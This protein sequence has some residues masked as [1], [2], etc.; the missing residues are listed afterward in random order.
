M[1]SNSPNRTQHASEQ[2]STDQSVFRR[3]TAQFQSEALVGQQIGVWK[4]TALLGEG[5]MSVVYEAQHTSEERTAAIKLLKPENYQQEVQLQRFHQEA[6]TIRQFDHENIIKLYDFAE[7]AEF[8]YYMVLERLRGRDFESVIQEYA[9]LPMGW[10]LGVIEQICQAIETIHAEGVLHR[11]LK[12]S[13]VFLLSDGPAPTVKLLDFGIAKVHVEENQSKLTSTGTIIGTPSYLSPEQIKAQSSLTEATDLYSLGVIIYQA[14]TG[15]LPLEGDSPIDQIIK[16]LHNTPKKLGFHRPEF[17]G[18]VLEELLCQTLS[19]I[20]GERPESIEFLWDE[21][22]MAGQMLEDPLD[23][24]DN[25]PEIQEQQQAPDLPTGAVTSPANPTHFVYDGKN[26]SS[27][28]EINKTP[29]M[30]ILSGSQKQ[31]RT[32][33]F[34]AKSADTISKTQSLDQSSPPLPQ[35]PIEISSESPIE[36]V[37]QAEETTQSSWQSFPMIS[38]WLVVLVVLGLF[39]IFRSFNNKIKPFKKTT[40]KKRLQSKA[41][42]QR[43]RDAVKDTERKVREWLQQGA[44]AYTQKDY[45]KAII[46]WNKVIRHGSWPQSVHNPTLYLPLSEAYLKKGHLYSAWWTL[47]QFEKAPTKSSNKQASSA[48]QKQ[49][50]FLRPS[51]AKTTQVAKK[52]KELHTQIKTRLRKAKRL[53]SRCKTKLQRRKWLFALVLYKRLLTELPSHPQWQLQTGLVLEQAFPELAQLRL[54]EV[55]GHL[56]LNASQEKQWRVQQEKLAKHIA[57]QKSA[58][59]HLLKEVEKLLQQ[60]S[61]RKVLRHLKKSFT[62]HQFLKNTFAQE[63]FPKWL[64]KQRVKKPN[65]ALA[66]WDF[67][68]KR[69]QKF[70]QSELWSWL[71]LQKKEL[72]SLQ[73]LKQQRK[74]IEGIVLWYNTL[75]KGQRALGKGQ[76][77]TTRKYLSKSLIH[78]KNLEERDIWGFFKVHLPVQR[79]TKSLLK[80]LQSIAPIQKKFL[81]DYRL[82]KLEQAKLWQTE[83]A[84]QLQH[85]QEHAQLVEQSKQKLIRLESTIG[86]LRR[87]NQHFQK[88]QLNMQIM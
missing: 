12:P 21:L 70:V 66:L 87:A 79:S 22:E 4:L 28:Q 10:L 71:Q 14:I 54:Q 55:K 19:K 33:R 85:A 56:L 74:V 62:K 24:G 59:E 37:L 64:E 11:D 23:L 7:D 26:V 88:K 72:P 30:P 44:A 51:P 73:T 6:E 80:N 35:E 39:G 76:F 65:Q 45:K 8:G 48:L 57:Q 13:N 77:S 9:P 40:I 83:L 18:T 52:T 42:P 29:L 16:V 43:P 69:Q 75:Q 61:I 41:A 58:F 34:E 53:L 17:S 67:Y 38:V 1:P 15:K 81:K 47:K 82:A 68:I 49:Y 46:D 84:R 25:I 50:D 20:P 31:G 3:F 63:A 36:E 27:I 78:W 86:I 32:A 60:K 2:A 5:G